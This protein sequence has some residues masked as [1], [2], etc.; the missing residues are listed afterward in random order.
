M[1]VHPPFGGEI[2]LSLL[3]GG[4]P[5]LPLGG[6]EKGA[7]LFGKGPWRRVTSGRLGLGQVRSLL[8]GAVGCSLVEVACLACEL[9]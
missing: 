4:G 2:P 6:G 3:R 5:H 1:H 7:L 9:T 8:L